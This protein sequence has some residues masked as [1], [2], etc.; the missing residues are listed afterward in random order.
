MTGKEFR[1]WLAES[2]PGEAADSLRALYPEPDS[3]LEL[4]VVSTLPTREATM[5]RAAAETIFFAV[6]LGKPDPLAAR[7]IT[8]GHTKPELSTLGAAGIAPQRRLL[9]TA[10]AR[11]GPHPGYYDQESTRER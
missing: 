3:T 6:S 4:S 7:G 1:V 8:A 9:G 5:E 2:A 11:G 10:A